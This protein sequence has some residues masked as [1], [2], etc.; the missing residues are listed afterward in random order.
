MKLLLNFKKILLG[1]QI[2]IQLLLLKG[3]CIVALLC[4]QE[5]G[6]GKN[7]IVLGKLNNKSPYNGPAQRERSSWKRF[8]SGQRNMEQRKPRVPESRPGRDRLTHEYW[9]DCC[10]EVTCQLWKK[11]QASTVKISF[12]TALVNTSQSPIQFSSDLTA[13]VVYQQPS[14]YHTYIS[15]CKLINWHSSLI[16]SP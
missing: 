14:V 7:T 13:T 1:V 16:Q 2:K 5:L 9:S 11:Y 15:F 10:M 4:Q 12:F 3:K 6:Y 8:P